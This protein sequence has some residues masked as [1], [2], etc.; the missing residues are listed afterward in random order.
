MPGPGSGC[1]LTKSAHA[2]IWWYPSRHWCTTVFPM[3]ANFRS[4]KIMKLPETA[5]RE[6]GDRGQG[7]GDR[8]KRRPGGRQGT[9]ECPRMDMEATNQQIGGRP[10]WR[11]NGEQAGG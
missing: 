4:S 10:T 9:G 6:T 3:S 7:T 2:A 1:A 11:R 5:G 8:G